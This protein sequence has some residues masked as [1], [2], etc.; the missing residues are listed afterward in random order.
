MAQ[1]NIV[2]IMTDTKPTQ[3]VGCY[4]GQDVQTNEMG[5]VARAAQQWSETNDRPTWI[6]I[7]SDHGDHLGAHRLRSKGPTGYDQNTVRDDGVSAPYFDYDSGKVTR[8]AKAQ[9]S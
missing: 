1:P 9:F 3:V 2:L 8:G 6:I 7:T 4:S 5:R